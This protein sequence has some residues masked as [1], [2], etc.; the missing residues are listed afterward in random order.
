[1]EGAPRRRF[2]AG[3]QS[4]ASTSA[5][6]RTVVCGSAEDLRFHR[7]ALRARRFLAGLKPIPSPGALNFANGRR[8]RLVM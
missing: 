6:L 4:C 3:L 8:G 5:A 7:A 2:F 1:M